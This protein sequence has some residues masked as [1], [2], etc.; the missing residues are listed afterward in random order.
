MRHPIII[1]NWKMNMLI[2]TADE[3]MRGLLGKL[4]YTDPI[5]I[6]VAPPFTALAVLRERIKNSRIQLAGQNMGSEL[7]GSQTGEI[8]AA[9]LK[10][11]GC[12][13][14]ILGHSERRQYLGETDDII[15]RKIS[16]ACDQGLNIIFCVGE[17][18]GNRSNGR[19]NEIIETQ[20]SSGL[21]DLAAMQRSQLGFNYFIS[22]T[23]TPVTKGLPNTK[24]NI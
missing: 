3:W 9:M 15:S 4:H 20:L 24:Y 6:V 12:D 16:V 22:S 19:T 18:L 7:E 8:S 5:D 13:Y 23:I 10:D 17:S 2:S 11:A 1:G 14:V 21:A